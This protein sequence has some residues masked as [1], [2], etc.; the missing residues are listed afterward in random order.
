MREHGLQCPLHPLQIG[1]L[2][3][4]ILDF[5]TYYLIN[6]S[7]LSYNTALVACLSLVYFLISVIVLVLWYKATRIDPSDPTI[8]LQ[9]MREAKGK[10]FDGTCYEYLCEICDTHVLETAKHCGSC[11]RCVNEFDHH[12]RWINNCVGQKNYRVFF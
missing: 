3:V 4:F 1:T 6:M 11:N 2:F 10:R 9:R 7:S 12:C 8:R 5:T